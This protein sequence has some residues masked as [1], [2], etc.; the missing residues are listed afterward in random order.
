M[1]DLYV[2]SGHHAKYGKDSFQPIRLPD[3]NKEFWLPMN[4]PHHCEIYRR[5]RVRNTM[6][7]RC[8]LR[9]L[10]TVYCY[11][12][13]GRACTADARALYADD[14]HGYG[15]LHFR[16]KPVLKMKEVTV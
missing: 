6:T 14:A 16:A 15:A 13:S 4:C 3:E 11:E 1:K 2:T 9:S 12:Q 7:R 5:C 10:G 8:V